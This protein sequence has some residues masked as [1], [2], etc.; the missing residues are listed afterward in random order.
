M[1]NKADSLAYL[2]GVGLLNSSGV[3][4]AQKSNSD[5]SIYSAMFCLFGH[6]DGSIAYYIS[7]RCTGKTYDCYETTDVY[8]WIGVTKLCAGSTKKK[9][10]VN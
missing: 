10:C 7:H 9:K 8:R 4:K 2:N 5:P 1:E 6:Y 3:K